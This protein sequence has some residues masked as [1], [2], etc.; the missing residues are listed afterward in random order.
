VRPSEKH[1]GS[2]QAERGEG[3]AL[4]PNVTTD[5]EAETE[6]PTRCVAGRRLLRGPGGPKIDRARGPP[7]AAP[8]IAVILHI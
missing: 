4:Q 1:H 2:S 6:R 7:D 8:A 3:N 5:E